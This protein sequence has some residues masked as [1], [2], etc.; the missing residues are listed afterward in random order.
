MKQ[1]HVV[2]RLKRGAEKLI[3]TCLFIILL[4][5]LCLY[6]LSGN[7]SPFLMEQLIQSA[8]ASTAISLFG[9][10]LLDLE[11]RRIERQ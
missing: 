4:Y 6:V 3:Y 7:I 9:G 1:K 11:I 2:P 10:L 5:M 8:F